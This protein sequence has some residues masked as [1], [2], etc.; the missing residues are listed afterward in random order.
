MERTGRVREPFTLKSCDI[1]DI[2]V[3]DYILDRVM[4]DDLRSTFFQVFLDGVW[5]A[6]L[7]CDG[8]DPAL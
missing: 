7:W 4:F 6:A 5:E 1:E 8:M 2:K 3:G